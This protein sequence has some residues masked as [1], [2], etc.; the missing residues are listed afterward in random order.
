MHEKIDIED[1]KELIDSRKISK[2]EKEADKK[3]LL[4]ARFESLKKRSGTEQKVMDL[5]RLK[6]LL[7]EEAKTEKLTSEF[8]TYSSAYVDLVYDT[9]KSFA[10]DINF[11]ET[12]VSLILSG[13]RPAT[14]EFVSKIK[15]HSNEVFKKLNINFNS[16]N[17]FTIYYLDRMHTYLN[18]NKKDNISFKNI[19]ISSLKIK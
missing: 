2:A 9:R 15:A 14:E 10:T 11:S 18:N 3:S 17:W 1:F 6:L 5:Y 7:E 8:Y 12:Q 16:H 13:K 19:N 4:K